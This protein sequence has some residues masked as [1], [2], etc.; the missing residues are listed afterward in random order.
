MKKLIPAVVGLCF[1][2]GLTVQAQQHTTFLNPN[3]A[4][5]LSP[6][7]ASTTL[8]LATI[9]RPGDFL[10]SVPSGAI[11]RIYF[12]SAS[13]SGSG[14]YSNF[15]V[16]MGQTTDTAFTSTTFPTLTLCRQNTLV[17][18]SVSVNGYIP[19]DLTTAF[20]YD[21]TKSLIVEIS[22]D[23]RT[24]GNG[25]SI[26]SNVR[27][28][29]NIAL[30][31][32]L[33]SNATGTFST[34]QRTLGIDL[35]SLALRDGG[36]TDFVSPAFP[37]NS[38][39]VVPVTVNVTNLGSN[40]ISQI[41]LNYRMG[42]RPVVTESFVTNLNTFT[43]TSLSFNTQLSLPAANDSVLEVWISQVN[44]S[45]DQV[46]ANDTIRRTICVPLA[47]GLYTVGSATADFVTVQAAIDRINCSGVAGNVTFSLLPG[48]Y[49]S[50][51]V[52]NNIPGSGSRI[53]F[54]SAG[55]VGSVLLYP[56][57]TGVQAP[58]IT[59][60]NENQI[61]LA[62]LTFV[63][64]V[65][66]TSSTPLVLMSNGA[67]LQLTSC[68]FIDSSLST[69]ANNRAVSLENCIRSEVT[70]NR[71]VGFA[72]AF[73]L[74]DPDT[75]LS[76]NNL[77]LQNTFEG[78]LGTAAQISGQSL[79]SFTSNTFRDFQGTFNSDAALVVNGVAN[80]TFSSNRWIGTLARISG[81]F[82][83]LNG[84]PGVPNAIYNNEITGQTSINGGT[85]AITAGFQILG[86]STGGPDYVQIAHNSMYF[87]A[88]S[89]ATSTSQACILLD[90]GTGATS[91]FAQ[92]E[93]LNN[94]ISTYPESA[95]S[96]TNFALVTVSGTSTRDTLVADR[97]VY[98]RPGAVTQQALFRVITPAASYLSL[99][100]WRQATGVDSNSVFSNP[101]FQTDSLLVPNSLQADNLGRPVGQIA[102]DI[103]GALRSATT[104]DPGAY[105]FTGSSQSQFTVVP[106]V[107]TTSLNNR[108]IS[109]TIV[110]SLGLVGGTNGPRMYFRKRGQ[111][112]FAVDQIPQQ[113]GINFTF[114]FNY[115]LI[116]GIQPNDTIEYYFATLNN[117][118]TV[119]TF[120]ASGGG[121][122]PIGS[123]PPPILLR[124]RIVPSALSNYTIGV[125]GNFASITAA[126]TFINTSNFSGNT[127][128]TLIDSVYGQNEVFPI[129]F[130]ANSTLGPNRR[131]TILPA[132]GVNVHIPIT[133]SATVPA[134]FRFD[135]A[136]YITFDGSPVNDT[137]SRIRLEANNAI[138]GSALIWLRGSNNLGNNNL[139]FRNLSF[140]GNGE[141]V[142]GH[143]AI[144][145][146]ANTISTAGQGSNYQIRI[147]QN[148]FRRI[149]QGIYFRGLATDPVDSIYILGNRFGDELATDTMRLRAIEINTSSH[150]KIEGNKIS[151]II[152]PLNT[153]SP[154]AIEAIIANVNLVIRNNEI[155]SIRNIASTGLTQGAF[156]I[157]VGGTGVL[158]VNNV[159]F[160]LTTRNAG[161]TSINQPA[162]IRIT[163]TGHKLYYNSVHLN[164]VHPDTSGEGAS[165]ALLLTGS[166]ITGLDVRNNVFA[167]T[168]ST[169]SNANAYFAAIW[170][171]STFSY[172]GST[173]NHN[174]YYVANHPN[175]LVGRF[176]TLINQTLCPT[177]DDL[178]AVARLTN[179]LSELQSVPYG[180]KTPPSFV[181][182]N[183]LRPSP[184]IPTMLES[185]GE[186]IA[187]IDTP[188]VDIVGSI[189]PGLGGSAPDIGAYEFTGIR[190]TDALA[191]SI[192]S[193][194]VNPFLAQCF[195]TS[196][197]VQ[198][199][200]RDESKIDSVW[201]FRAVN[202]GPR[203]RQQMAFV[204]GRADSGLWQTNVLPAL[205]GDKVHL[206]VQAK[207]S[208]GNLT[209]LKRIY[210]IRDAGLRLLANQP[211]T[212]FNTTN[213]NLRL[214]GRS[215]IGGLVIS[216]MTYTR[217]GTGAQ[218]NYP[219][220]FPTESAV[221]AIEI[222]NT[223]AEPRSL[224]GIQLRIEGIKSYEMTLPNVVLDTQKVITI[225]GGTGVDNPQSGVYFFGAPSNSR[226]WYLSSDRVGVYL[227]D[228][229]T[230]EVFD[231]VACRQ[232]R[233]APNSPV[234]PQE[235]FNLLVTGSFGQ[236]LQGGDL[237]PTTW[238][239]NSQNVVST[240]GTYN[241]QLNYNRGGYLWIN[242]ASGQLVFNG[243]NA[244]FMPAVSG[245]Y[246]LNFSA[247]GCTLRDTF[248]ITLNQPDLRIA[249][250]L[251]PVAGSIVNGTANTVR[252]RIKNEGSL[253]ITTPF[254][255]NYRAAG[256]SIFPTSS[257]VGL[258]AGDSTELTLSPA[259]TP[260]VGGQLQF[261][262]FLNAIAADPNRSNDT[263]CITLNSTVSV[264]EN[265]LANAR[266]YPNPTSDQLFIHLGDFKA[267]VKLEVL[268]VFGRTVKTEELLNEMN[269]ISLADLADGQYV[270]R[271][272]SPHELRAMRLM[273]V[274]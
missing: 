140:F 173:F 174:A 240:L 58:T 25:F 83:N 211:D 64:S 85:T 182:F 9:Y 106:L 120:P 177:L 221:T 71:F 185:G 260:T 121:T 201:L 163:G 253:A 192:D 176:G 107:D 57:A 77:V 190:A 236:Q 149:A 233:W 105:E 197:V 238:D 111:A 82:T 234:L 157:N 114:L 93:L 170:I 78:A 266:I 168:M 116:G 180:P 246:I 207:D 39:A 196:R 38:G 223:S 136:A 90:G 23:S 172:S 42:N 108:S 68:V 139:I 130:T 245:N 158:I 2:F 151:N 84:S 81:S 208:L 75:I 203:V 29:T 92:L 128:F 134:M 63:R 202:N 94:V 235:A 187:G 169:P 34:G 256:G 213:G 125:N 40:P 161:S 76:D 18:P 188:N 194:S 32:P 52:L 214:R 147:Q 264:E 104:P 131:V 112:N 22:Y 47:A 35:A 14:T 69:N 227:I 141:A 195:P 254:T 56:S 137:S 138:T 257:T 156:G 103:T 11:N 224:A 19:I 258:A 88:R 12:A 15:T 193:I 123:I 55:G 225:V 132:V 3:S 215:N 46:N 243:S 165:A 153:V 79:L 252:V 265:N 6:F 167:N 27:T 24:A 271:L 209:P 251:N 272:S 186:F 127:T 231:A 210:T 144:Y 44:G 101:V 206:Y 89:T 241:A 166:N 117:S 70:S 17:V 183:N 262:A 53:T 248:V 10:T 267:S 7:S 129:V 124:Y 8:K 218:T 155:R 198:L 270:L 274:R 31:A 91:N 143:Y 13:G 219:A 237:L 184:V 229:A 220:G 102:T 145:G 255:V 43:S 142:T 126:A 146:G 36:L 54:Q 96:P 49:R 72:R 148:R 33:A 216:E 16:R 26:R 171:S 97:N 159:I 232:Y 189:R 199:W 162:G 99:Q 273:V 181:G 204:S 259:W 50:N 74:T 48:V 110:D 178:A 261:C 21:S 230:L 212:L 86:S 269:T 205:P 95:S 109:I 30:T 1:L 222:S 164:G 249:R 118:G 41:Q 135:D 80:A 115:L 66:P 217:G 263:L 73:S 175:N 119:S 250:I 152:C 67:D 247:N 160:D 133:L 244:D 100:Q 87:Q 5:N 242:Q 28:G 59:I 62:Q 226:S 122:S 65:A 179:P 113:S 268:D 98:F 150:A 228:T 20:P 37:F 200:M 239:L 4:A 51:F 60:A 154:A 61:S 191:P 45:T